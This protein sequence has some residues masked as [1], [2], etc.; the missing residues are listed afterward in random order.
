[1]LPGSRLE[2]ALRAG[3]AGIEVRT[4]IA[5]Y[6]WF[7]DWGRDTMISLEGLTLATGRLREAAAILR[8]FARYVRDGL[9]PNLFPEDAREARY[10][11]IDATLWYF[12]ALDRFARACGSIDLV[13]ELFPVLEDI[14]AHHLAGTRFG[15]GVDPADGLLAGGGD[16]VALTWMDARFEDWVVTPRRGKPVEVQALWYN[17]LTLMAEWA[18]RSDARGGSTY[19]AR[20]RSAATFNA[21]FWN[22][23]TGRCSTSSTGPTATTR[24][25]APTR[26]S[27]FAPVSDPRRAPMACGRRHGAGAPADA[28]RPAHP[29]AR[30][31]RVPAR[32]PRRSPHARCGVPPGHGVALADRPLRRRLAAG[33]RGPRRA[34]AMLEAFPAH[35]ARPASAA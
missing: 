3:A 24:A 9:L 19:G 22:A 2:E 1:M 25:A 28:V 26:S 4:V 13:R 35:L 8:T 18:A 15:I 20:P 30:R 32:L 12:H 31:G 7:G 5:G 27:R 33:V 23:R 29:R 11:T 16:G 14:V 21:R 10:N 17:A 6:H 34:R